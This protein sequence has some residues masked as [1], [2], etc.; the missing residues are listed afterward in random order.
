MGRPIT[1]FKWN[2]SRLVVPQ[3]DLSIG[4]G[5]SLY[6]FCIRVSHISHLEVYWWRRHKRCMQMTLPP[7]EWATEWH[8]CLLMMV[9][10]IPVSERPGTSRGRC[11]KKHAL[12]WPHSVG[13]VW[14]CDTNRKDSAWSRHR[15]LQ[16]GKWGFIR[17]KVLVI[18]VCWLC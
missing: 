18:I 1:R 9:L 2:T 6:Y 16:T 14:P 8:A 10:E 4:P 11:G 12:R 17:N 13:T 7:T 15:P 3:R 5:L